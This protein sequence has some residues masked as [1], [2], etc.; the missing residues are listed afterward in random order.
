MCLKDCNLLFIIPVCSFLISCNPPV[1][2]RELNNTDSLSNKLVALNKYL[3][4]KDS[5]VIEDYIAKKKWKVT[6][7]A[8]A[9][10][11]EIYKHGNGKKAETGKSATIKY[12]VEL[13]DGTLCYT[14]DSLGLKTFQIGEGG[15][16]SGLEQGILMMREGD[17]AHLI[18]PPHLAHGLTGDQDKIGPRSI[19]IYDVELISVK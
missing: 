16:E 6:R 1:Q 19:I 14:S 15:V 11:Y 8:T 18:L 5:A 9:L 13:S 4:G 2:E 3:V 7:T 10:C 12:R 17:S